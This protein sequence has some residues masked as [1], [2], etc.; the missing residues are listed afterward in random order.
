[1]PGRTDKQDQLVLA[2]KASKINIE[3]RDGVD[4]DEILEKAYP[5]VRYP[6][7]QLTSIPLTLFIALGPKSVEKQFRLLPRSYEYAVR[8]S[9]PPLLLV[10]F[11]G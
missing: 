4:G 11:Y 5:P 8:V 3:F 2:G 7:L 1:M 10:D 6:A 9:W